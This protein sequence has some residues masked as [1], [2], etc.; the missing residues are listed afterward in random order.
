M[1][2]M[3]STIINPFLKTTITTFTQM[4]GFAPKLGRPFLVK[5]QL[6]HGW[7]IS[8]IIGIVGDI[9][10]ILVMR[11]T[12]EFALKLLELSGMGYE[13]QEECDELKRALVAETVNV[14]SGNALPLLKADMVDITPPVVIQ[15]ENHTISWPSSSPKIGIPFSTDFGEFEIQ[16]SITSS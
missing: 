3:D 4:F 5:Q 7:N 12:E 2:N 6:T 10:G 8:G 11:L 14:I 1:N 16:I 9:E 15:G 13:D